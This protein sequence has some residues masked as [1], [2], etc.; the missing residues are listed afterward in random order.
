MRLSGIRLLVPGKMS[1]A[2]AIISALL[3]IAAFPDFEYWY[4]AWFAPALLFAA[5]RL[6]S[7][8]PAR[9]MTVGWIFGVS[10]F[11][12]AFWWLTFAPINYAGFPPVLAYLLLLV[13]CMAVAVFPAMFC[14]ILAVTIR[15]FGDN[16]LFAAPFIWVFSEFLRYWLT[17]NNWNAIAYSQAFAGWSLSYASIGGI[18]LVSFVLVFNSAMLARIAAEFDRKST[19]N[20]RTALAGIAVAIAVVSA[21]GFFGGREH[22]SG[23]ERE[24]AA[25]VIALQPNVPMSGL[26]M[27]SWKALRARHVEL[28]EN[29]LNKSDGNYAETRPT[30]I[31]IFPESPMNFAYEEDAEFREFVGAFARR[32]NVSVLFNSAEPNPIDGKYFNSAVMVD[33]RGIEVAQYDKIFLLPFGETVPDFLQGIVP[34]FV[35]NFSRGT[36][37][38][39]L[40]LA[41]AKSGVMICF[42]S[43]FG[44][45]SREYVKKGAD[46]LIEMTNDGYLGNTPVLRQHLANAIF[47]AVETNR[48]VL[49]V[50]NVGV[51]ALIGENGEILDSAESY[52]QDVRT[53]EVR[54]SDGV[55]TFYVRFGDWF[56]WLS[57]AVALSIFI[58]GRRRGR[59]AAK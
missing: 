23:N 12:G 58:I 1:A 53:W 38:D 19:A 16:A 20:R 40:P 25:R 31:V 4:T 45:L 41:D 37:E 18:Y 2:L 5:A 6:E 36:E 42:E 43:H 48:P 15:R 22:S 14:G 3:L 32:N 27:E 44:Q 46:V 8:S 24:V 17:G 57:A 9:A 55:S 54:K 59:H 51:T 35:G 30:T 28:A 13:V 7:E 34:T 50:T 33:N 56:A 52:K 49:R 39:I 29:A 21:S 26:T 11:F 10:F 47:R